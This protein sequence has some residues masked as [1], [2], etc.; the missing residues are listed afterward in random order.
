MSGSTWVQLKESIGADLPA[1]NPWM[2]SPTILLLLRAIVLESRPQLVLEA[3][4]GIST[5]VLGYSL[6]EAGA[7]RVVAMED[8]PAFVEKTIEL[9]GM[10]GL[11][12]IASVVHAPLDEYAFGPENWVWYAEHAWSELESIDVVVVNGPSSVVTEGVRYPALPL[13]AGHLADRAVVALDDS[14]RAGER[15]IL[16][17]WRR[18]FP[19]FQVR[20]VP[21]RPGVSSFLVHGSPLPSALAAVGKTAEFHAETRRSINAVRTAVQSFR[22]RLRSRSAR[23]PDATER[24]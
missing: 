23:P 20:H 12:G 16:R 5:V 9:I 15:R 8:D 6:R 11:T 13:L 14:Q 17:R 18:D 24:R 4:S 7:G 10:H 19:E 2:L 22:S 21:R 1:Y 3:G